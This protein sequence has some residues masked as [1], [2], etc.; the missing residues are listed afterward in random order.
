[1]SNS[2]VFM[3]HVTDLWTALVPATKVG[4]V[5]HHMDDYEM[6]DDTWF[7]DRGFRWQVPQRVDVR[8]EAAD[9]QTVLVEWRVTAELYLQRQGQ[10][11]F[12]FMSAA[13][14]EANDLMLTVERQSVWP[15]GIAEV[16]TQNAAGA[17]DEDGDVTYELTFT[18]IC[19]ETVP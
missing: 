5:Y 14:S 8:S 19:E 10:S 6:D 7:Q 3:E 1:M 13:A 18:L 12:S 15:S 16:I 17:E 11:Y 2:V 4:Q 9:G